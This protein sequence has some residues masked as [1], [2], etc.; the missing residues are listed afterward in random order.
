MRGWNPSD[1]GAG[2][3]VSI[4]AAR[5]N[6]TIVTRLLDGA[7]ATLH[8]QG[9]DPRAIAIAWVPGSFELPLAAAWAAGGA[10]QAVAGPPHAVVALGCVIRGE[11]EHFRLVADA[12]S[13]GLL[14]VGLDTGVP[15][16]NGVLA[17]EDV[18]QAES[19][20]GGE[21]GNAGAQAALA[22]VRMANFKRGRGAS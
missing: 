15:V 7:V 19:R 11:T 9:V 2:L 6:E 16:T 21:H 13:Q 20:A 12:A 5:W 10:G 17:V 8:A 3:R 1:D 22:A 18:A 14:R 4:V